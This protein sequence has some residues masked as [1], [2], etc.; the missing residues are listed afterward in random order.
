VGMVKAVIMIGLLV[1]VDP[2]LDGLAGYLLFR[3]GYQIFGS[4]L[5]AINAVIVAGALSALLP[6]RLR[7]PGGE[8]LAR[9]IV[10]NDLDVWLGLVALIYSVVVL[11]WL[12][13]LILV[14]SAVL[15]PIGR[16]W[17]VTSL[18]SW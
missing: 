17:I 2:S 10:R 6:R 5:L 3:D 13:I 1:F 15:L 9:A 11:E 16:R 8:T 18:S 4:L 7:P 12:P 14:V